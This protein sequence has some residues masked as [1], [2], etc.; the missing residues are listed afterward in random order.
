M[1]SPMVIVLL[2]GFASFAWLA[3][4]LALRMMQP[5]PLIIS[6]AVG[7]GGLAIFFGADAIKHATTSYDLYVAVHRWTFWSAFVPIALW[8]HFCSL[9]YRQ[10]REARPPPWDGALRALVVAAYGLA[11]LLS[12]LGGATDQLVDYQTITAQPDA[13]FRIAAGPWYPMTIAFNTLLSIGG[14]FCLLQARRCVS[15]NNWS[16][17]KTLLLQLHLLIGGGL[18]FWAGSLWLPLGF[19]LNISRIPGILLVYAGLLVLGYAVAHTGLLFAGQ[20]TQRDFGY[21]L[22]AILFLILLYLGVIAAVGQLN[23]LGTLSIILLVIATHS[24]F[25]LGRNILDR[26]F[27]TAEEQQARR[28]A[29]DY[30]SVLGTQPVDLR[31]LTRAEVAPQ[32]LDCAPLPAAEQVE[33]STAG[34]PPRATPLPSSSMAPTDPPTAAADLPCS[35]TPAAEPAP[36]LTKEFKQSVRR[37]ITDLKSPPQLAQSPLLALPLVT[38]RL[39]HEQRPDHRLNRAAILREL[40]LSYIEALRPTDQAAPPASDAWRFYNV[41]YYPYVREISRKAALSELRRLEATG[42]NS[43]PHVAELRTVLDWLANVEEATFY[44]WQ[45]RASDII[46]ISLWEDNQTGVTKMCR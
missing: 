46:A 2:L 15:A 34:L 6:G 18:L 45:R 10:V 11:L 35:D 43:D 40:L 1:F 16:G 9:L 20:N 44:K 13:T 36:A 14:L 31:G 30:A 26:L 4:Y 17:R 12:G 37:A 7:L 23:V 8:L 29:R 24:A 21:S 27:F 5:N 39:A 32:L 28:E 41:L 38:A 33:A 22:T 3:I 19:W 25:D 42:A